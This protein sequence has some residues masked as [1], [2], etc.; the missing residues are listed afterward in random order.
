MDP[1]VSCNR[2]VN[3]SHGFKNVTIPVTVKNNPKRKLE[4][5]IDLTEEGAKTNL[6]N[7]REDL[8]DLTEDD[9]V[10]NSRNKQKAR[11]AAGARN[12]EFDNAV[13]NDEPSAQCE[14]F[15][16]SDD[17]GS[18]KKVKPNEAQSEQTPQNLPQEQL[19][20]ECGTCREQF[21]NIDEFNAHDIKHK[22][23]RPPIRCRRCRKTFTSIAERNLHFQTSP[24]HF[25]C[26]YCKPIIV[27]FSKADS[28]RYHY[29]DRHV[30]LYC[31][32]CNLHFSNPFQRLSH[33]DGGHQTCL[34]CRKMF[35]VPELGD[36]YCRTCYPARFGKGFPEDSNG[37]SI[38]A[39]LPDHYA[40][41]GISR[42]SSHEQVLKAAKEMR[43]KTH[44]DRLKR[45][46]GLSEDEIRVIDLEAALVGEAADVLSDP[47]MR[48]RYDCKMRGW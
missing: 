43:V 42:G 6:K 24:R 35:H 3:G 25:C 31:H 27:E 40:R 5:V 44:P 11:E 36:G 10:D 47:G 9:V 39:G 46:E 19:L 38:V 28:L 2:N 1:G 29:I 37:D 32:H 18:R 4:N 45:R 7:R 30:E 26:R 34:D 8:I 33:M 16:S 12:N 41:L 17:H 48:Y 22:Q 15:H 14:D 13:N 20:F 23:P 21:D